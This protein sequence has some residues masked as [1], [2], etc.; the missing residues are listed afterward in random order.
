MPSVITSR[1]LPRPLM[2]VEP[3][4]KTKPKPSQ[5]KQ[6]ELR[7]D[8]GLLTSKELADLCGTKKEVVRDAVRSGIIPTP[9]ES[10]GQSN[11]RYHRAE[12]AD[13]LKDWLAK[14]V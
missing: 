13:R 5:H 12:V 2:D 10:Y 9:T 14:R 3:R 1:Q 6:G 4:K 8:Y 11:A 7:R